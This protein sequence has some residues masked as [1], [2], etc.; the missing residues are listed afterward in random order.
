MI[1]IGWLFHLYIV[2]RVFLCVIPTWRFFF[3]FTL[4][5][6]LI[7]LGFLVFGVEN[8]STTQEKKLVK[9]NVLVNMP[10]GCEKSQNFK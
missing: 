10:T 6:T 4:R 3:F 5:F 1:L 7:L 9:E 8:I 2:M